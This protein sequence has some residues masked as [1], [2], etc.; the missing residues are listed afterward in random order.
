MQMRGIALNLRNMI[1]KPSETI[2]HLLNFPVHR[3]FYS[4]QIQT[5]QP[6]LPQKPSTKTMEG[7]LKLFPY[8]IALRSISIACKTR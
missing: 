7:F 5:Y 6:L 3:I 4:T 2:V 1:T 8:L